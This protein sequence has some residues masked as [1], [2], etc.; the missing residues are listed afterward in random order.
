M[1]FSSNSTPTAAA[2]NVTPLIDVLLV[3]LIIFMVIGPALPHG[4]D[5]SIPEP[6]NHTATPPLE[7]L[8]VRVFAG[9]NGPHYRL[10]AKDIGLLEVR[11][12]LQALLAAREDT[13]EARA[14]FVQADRSL[15]Y[16][17]VARVVSE[18][19]A[20]GAGSVALLGQP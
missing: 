9:A 6:P 15:E 16:R 18:V 12:A 7:P 11:P 1:A 5:S 19:R 8:T 2:I 4:L 14:V 20:A 3:L 17:D 10:G 13:P